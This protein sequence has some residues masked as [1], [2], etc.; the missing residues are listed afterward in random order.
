[1]EEIMKKY[2]DLINDLRKMAIDNKDKAREIAVAITNL[3]TSQL[4][5]ETTLKK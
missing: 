4:W 3:Q 1:M 2:D 5:Y